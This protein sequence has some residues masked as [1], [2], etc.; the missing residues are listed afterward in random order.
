MQP[1]N[2]ASV[3][4][5]CEPL[6]ESGVTSKA[7]EPLFVKILYSPIVVQFGKV[8]AKLEPEIRFEII[9]VAVALTA[10]AE[11]AS[12]LENAALFN[13]TEP[14]PFGVIIIFKFVPLPVAESVGPVVEEPFAIVNSF[15]A[16]PVAVIFITSLPE[17]SLIDVPTFGVF[18]VGDVNVLLV[19][20][21]IHYSLN[22]KP[23]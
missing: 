8:T 18:K 16:L 11:V 13:S 1:S 15:T 12:A 19:S 21:C 6:K 14:V 5:V 10:P 4:L 3:N 23:V 9:S 20:V 22:N 17:V 2:C 7:S